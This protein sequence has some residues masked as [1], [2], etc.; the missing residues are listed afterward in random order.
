MPRDGRLFGRGPLPQLARL[1][2]IR[3]AGDPPSMLT[4]GLVMVIGWLPLALLAAAQSG[5]LDAQGLGSFLG[6]IAV[7]ARSLV[8]VPLLVLADAACAP[9]LGAIAYHFLD[10][11]LV[12]EHRR[13]DFEKAVAATRRSLDSAPAAVVLLGLAYAACLGLLMSGPH[14]EYPAW[15]LRALEPADA[16]SPFR[17]YSMAGWW[18]GLVSLPLLLLLILGWLWRLLLWGRL[19]WR[20]ART[21]LRLVPSHP[22]LCAGLRFVGHSLRAFA[23]VALA[24]GVVGAGRLANSVVYAGSSP[25]A[26][27]YALA[28]GAIVVVAMFL[29][30]LLAFTP[31]LLWQW[32]R[33][34]FEYGAL[35]DRVARGLERRWLKDDRAGHGRDLAS[36]DFSTVADLYQ[37]TANVHAM[38]LVPVDLKS[39]LLLVGAVLLP[40]VP[41]AMLALPMGTLARTLVR[42]FL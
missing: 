27:P 22:D 20:I 23:I 37:I 39:F 32:R 4:A 7:H 31:Q 13:P 11:G 40:F 29:A 15:Q 19:L 5:W 10:A 14:A 28:V 2:G 30:P 6:D 38:R 25:F 12:P 16:V 21:E 34:V 36:P 41:V 26:R 17:G 33:G 9:R 18:H 42:L 35:S 24:L 3:L 8:A 1:L